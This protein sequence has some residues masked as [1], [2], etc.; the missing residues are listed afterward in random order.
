M[1]SEPHISLCWNVYL[2]FHQIER[3]QMRCKEVAKTISPFYISL[4]HSEVFLNETNSRSFIALLVEKG[5]EELALM[6]GK[7]NGILRN[8][9][10]PVKDDVKHHCSI[11]YSTNTNIQF[12]SQVEEEFDFLASE[13]YCKVGSSH[14]PCSFKC[15]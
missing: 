15:E 7:I 13:L 12:K 6:Q 1:E 8:F 4:K 5:R 11:A 9:D 3:F 14:L 2:K 10:Q